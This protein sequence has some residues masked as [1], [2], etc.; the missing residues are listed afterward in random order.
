MSPPALPAPRWHNYSSKINIVPGFKSSTD[1]NVMF[2]LQG[3]G[4]Y[5]QGKIV[6]SSLQEEQIERRERK[7]S[8]RQAYI[9]HFGKSLLLVFVFFRVDKVK[10]MK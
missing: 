1:P 3:E 8:G 6:G 5:F 9:F 10:T 4:G 7:D 2:K